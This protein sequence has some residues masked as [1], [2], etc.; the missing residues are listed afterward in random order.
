ME[1][2]LIVRIIEAVSHKLSLSREIKVS[3]FLTAT[4]ILISLISVLISWSFDRKIRLAKEADDIRAAAA[5]SLGEL[6]RWNDLSFRCIR[7]HNLP[8][9]M[10]VKLQLG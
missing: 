10:L 6:E 1:R 3:D 8:L 2:S 7:K 5:S 9:W 4:T